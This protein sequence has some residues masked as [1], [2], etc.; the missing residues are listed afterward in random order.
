[1]EAEETEG[2]NAGVW[3]P[4]ADGGE[5]WRLLFIMGL[6]STEGS[7]RG[8]RHST[9]GHTAPLGPDSVS[10][11]RSGF[12]CREAP[13]PIPYA[14]GHGDGLLLSQPDQP[15]GDHMPD[16]DHMPRGSHSVRGPLRHLLSCLSLSCVGTAGLISDPSVNVRG[17]L[18][19]RGSCP[20]Q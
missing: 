15:G 8:V 1:M 7:L 4:P 12:L 20:H 17:F 6:L 13:I 10:A 18:C 19:W 11:S 14:P 16:G 2:R 9:G 3:V 5:C